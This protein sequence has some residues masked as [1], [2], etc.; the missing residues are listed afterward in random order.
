MDLT[1][2]NYNPNAIVDDGSC[3]YGIVGVWTATN[4]VGDSSFIVS[5]MGVTI[6]SL[7]SSGTITATPEMAGYP[8]SL[9]FLSS[10]TAYAEFSYDN[11]IDTVT[12]STSGNNLTITDNDG[13][14]LSFDYTVSQ[15]DLAIVDGGSQDTS[16]IVDFGAGPMTL[17]ISYNYSNSLNFTRN[18]N[19]II[20]NNV[21]QRIGNTNHSWIAKPK[22]N[23][24]LKALK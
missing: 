9:E 6:D 2:T 3:I 22:F 24:I 17:D 12:Y 13:E 21:S 15:S 18:T 8:T 11:E 4:V 14:I 20:N 16:V 1:A 10:G 5:Y 23:N 7:S 19:G